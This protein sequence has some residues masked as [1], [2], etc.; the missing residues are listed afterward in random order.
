MK[1]ITVAALSAFAFIATAAYAATPPNRRGAAEQDD[2][3]QQGGWRKKGDDRKAFEDLPVGQEGHP[4]GQMK[5]CNKDAAGKKGDERK[6]FMKE[7]L[8]KGRR[9]PSASGPVAVAVVLRKSIHSR[10]RSGRCLACGKT[11]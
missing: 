3:L 2:R 8:N 9:V 4:A 11:A 7:C 6:A 1:T 5:T 10:T